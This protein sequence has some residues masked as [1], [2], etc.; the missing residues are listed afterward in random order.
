MN[1]MTAHGMMRKK[2]NRRALTEEELQDIKVITKRQYDTMR[3]GERIQ[4]SEFEDILQEV[5]IHCIKA[6]ERY[7][8]T[9]GK[10]SEFLAKRIIGS[11]IDMLRSHRWKSGRKP[12]EFTFP[13][14][15]IED[16]DEDILSI[17]LN[18]KA[19]HE[20]NEVKEKEDLDDLISTLSARQKQIAYLLSVGYKKIEIGNIIGI[21]ESR[22][23]QIS[24]EIGEILIKSGKVTGKR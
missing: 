2:M 14:I 16:D 8:D 4:T 22:V 20:R 5:Y 21:H 17:Y 6:M 3:I 10:V 13:F 19:K 11:I 23:S 7:D 15:D 18:K 24:G 9:K 12:I 1:L